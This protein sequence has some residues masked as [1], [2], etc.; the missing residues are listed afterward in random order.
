MPLLDREERNAYGRDYVRKK[1]ASGDVRFLELR[2]SRA[3]RAAKARRER[4]RL[5]VLAAKD[6]PCVDCKVKYPAE[7]MDLDHV[8]GKKEFNLAKAS[9]GVE[10]YKS[11]DVIAAELEKC[12]PR[13]PNCHRLRHYYESLG[14]RDGRQQ[15]SR[16]DGQLSCS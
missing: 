14:V 8:S 3:R 15:D 10:G 13:C 16:T 11:F 4:I 12:E 5:M 9:R 2:R 6:K 1:L 7:I